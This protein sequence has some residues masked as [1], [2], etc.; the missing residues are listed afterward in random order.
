MLDIE[1]SITQLAKIKNSEGSKT[2]KAQR[3]YALCAMARTLVKD[4]PHKDF[5]DAT[6]LKP[7]HIE[8]LLAHWQT[9]GLSP[10]TIKNNLSQLRTWTRWI[11]KEGLMPAS[12]DTLG[13]E[14]RSYVPET[15]RAVQF[16]DAHRERVPDV[17]LSIAFELQ[18]AFGLRREEVLKLIPTMADKGPYLE[19]LGSWC[20]NGKARM[21]P[22]RTDAQRTLLE[23]AK[24]LAGA[25]RPI[26]GHLGN[27]KS[28]MKAYER[29]CKSAG[30]DGGHGLRHR[31]AQERYQELTGWAAPVAGGPASK[32]LTPA[33][34]QNDKEARLII[35]NEL[36]HAREQITVTYLGR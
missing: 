6:R 2:T 33:M 18:Q 5:V 29:A 32:A 14:R 21:V 16:T 10:A 25:G 24:R 11:D 31:Y 1:Y 12:N 7:K 20:K 30:F 22:I 27:Y 8:A 28:A 3:L 34:R 15:T 9:R 23:Q 13:A 17:R 26:G 35:S 4:L 36:G 19:L